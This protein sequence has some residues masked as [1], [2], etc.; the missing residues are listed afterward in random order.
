MTALRLICQLRLVDLGLRLSDNYRAS[1]GRHLTLTRIDDVRRW[2]LHQTCRKSRTLEMWIDML[3][4]AKVNK[5]PIDK[6]S[7]TG[8]IPKP[9]KLMLLSEE[10][11]L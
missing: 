7:G 6:I 5:I 10:L 8:G 3:L 2:P 1:G 9:T 11:G 4:P